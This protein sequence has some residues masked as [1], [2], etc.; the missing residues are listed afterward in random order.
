MLSTIF[1]RKHFIAAMRDVE[2][3]VG[4]MFENWFHL[5]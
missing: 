3:G 2:S 4:G 1:N 5:L